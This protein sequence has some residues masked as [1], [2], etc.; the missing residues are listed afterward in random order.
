[1]TDPTE[2]SRHQAVHIGEVFEFSVVNNEETGIYEA[3]NGD[4]KIA[5]LPYND[6]GSDRLLLLATSVFPEYRHRGVATE[7]IRRVLDDVRAHGKT[8]TIMCPITRSF[9][10]RH[11]DYADL[12]DPKHP[13]LAAV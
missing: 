2:L 8:V 7:L 3:V 10:E 13:G 1:M 6:A 11:P 12:I 5:G 9:I 4:T